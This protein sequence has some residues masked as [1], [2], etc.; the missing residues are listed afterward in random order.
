MRDILPD[1]VINQI[2]DRYLAGVADAEA[3][4]KYNSAD[5]D[6][7]TGALGGALSTSQPFTLIYEGRIYQVGIEVY[8]T[9]GRGA[10]APEKT[11]GND[12]IFQ[13]E[14]RENGRPLRRKG[15]PFQAKNQWKGSNS[16][17]VSQCK[18]MRDKFQAGIAVNYHPENYSACNIDNVIGAGGKKKELKAEGAIHPLGQVLGNDFLECR[19]GR[20]GLYYD[21]NV[22][23]YL[24][25]DLPTWLLT[26]RIDSI[27]SG[28]GRG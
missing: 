7:L 19:V 15:L 21:P 18:K 4:Y 2:R 8:K 13:I 12:G 6:A 10:G 28:E 26:T 25:E 24:T 14:V 22:Q 27:G 9:R 20:V 3:K 23:D 11:D 5:E 16:T 1:F 17:L